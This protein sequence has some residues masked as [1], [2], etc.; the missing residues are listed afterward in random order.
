MKRVLDSSVF[1]IDYPVDGELYTTHS[2]IHELV[3][4]SSKCRYET[5]L[6]VGL[7]VTEPQNKTRETVREAAAKA[8]ELSVLSDTDI[9]VIGLALEL[10]AE[11][12][13][14]DFAVQNVARH[15]SLNVKPVMQKKAKKRRWKYRC[16][17]CGRFGTAPGICDVCGAEFKRKL[18]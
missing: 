9:D 4:L 15:L 1:F 6:T 2:V 13:S 12:V 8:G 3:D 5:M 10:G 18:K 14:D 11:V 16:S 7:V 17:G